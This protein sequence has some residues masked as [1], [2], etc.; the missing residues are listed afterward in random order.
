LQDKEMSLQDIHWDFGTVSL[1][2]SSLELFCI[3]GIRWGS[4]FINFVSIRHQNQGLTHAKQAVLLS[5]TFWVWFVY[6]WH[7]GLVNC[8]SGHWTHSA[9]QDRLEFTILLSQFLI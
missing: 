3:K 5:Y 9:A 1:L 2:A 7:K 8:P 4:P 6:F